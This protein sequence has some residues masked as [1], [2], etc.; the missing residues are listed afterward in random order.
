MGVGAICVGGGDGCVGDRYYGE[1][2]ARGTAQSAPSMRFG[3]RLQSR[4]CRMGSRRRRQQVCAIRSL[5][6]MGIGW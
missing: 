6:S 5:G 1:D 2:D 4:D 3:C